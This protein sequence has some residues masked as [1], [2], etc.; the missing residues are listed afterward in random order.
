MLPTRRLVTILILGFSGM[1]AHAQMPTA[2]GYESAPDSWLLGKGH[3]WDFRSLTAASP[4]GLHQRPPYAD[5]IPVINKARQLIATG[6]AK[7]IALID[8]RTVVWIGFKTPDLAGKRLTGLGLGTTITSLAAGRAICQGKLSLDSPV[9]KFLPELRDTDLGQARL[10]HL[11]TMS[12]GTWEG[13]PDAT[14]INPEQQ[15]GINDGRINLIQILNT[16]LINGAQRTLLGMRYEPGEQFIYHSTDPLTVGVMINRATGIRYAQFVEQEILLPAG[17]SHTAIIG[18][19]QF[20]YGLSDGNLRLTPEDWIRV[21]VWIRERMDSNDCLAK[22]LQDATHTR[23]SNR[24][25]RFGSAF[26]GYGY[27]FWTE[28][29]RLNG[30]F[31]ALG[32]GGQRIGWNPRNHR[33][34]V[35]FSSIGNYMDELY[36][37]YRDWAQLP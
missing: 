3:A 30:S 19:D 21:A 34:L 1:A 15:A 20:G 36:R 4:T 35:A 10:R 24:A 13:N 11:L 37:L 2:G 8:G 33:V 16:P 12:S 28:N 26:D 6:P 23:I 7:V 25:H 29:T 17:I 27:F 32:H 5:E 14:I 31:W 18:Q 9:G 22:Y